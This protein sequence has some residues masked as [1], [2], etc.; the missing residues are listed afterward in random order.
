MGLSRAEISAALIGA[1]LGQVRVDVGFTLPAGDQVMAPLM[2]HGHK[3][4]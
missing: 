4:A 2:G 1:G 3:Q